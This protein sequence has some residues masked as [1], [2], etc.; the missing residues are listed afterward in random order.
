MHDGRFSYPSYTIRRKFFQIFGGTFY[1]YGPSGEMV[2]FSRQ[3]R[4]RLREDI[5]LYTGEDMAQEVL[6][7]QARQIMDFSAAYDIIDPVRRAKVGAM[8]RR[9][10]KS[11][12][13]DEWIMMDAADREIGAVR[14]DSATRAVIRRVLDQ[15]IP[16]SL[17]L[18]QAYHC[19]IGGAV[20]AVFKQNF[21]PFIMT[22][23]LDFSP[24]TAGL[25]DRRMGMAAGVLLC[26]IEGKE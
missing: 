19:E 1:V 26:A 15:F 14:E 22:L 21:N 7:I 25:L 6:T 8:K 5:R 9:G 10:L 17:I 13:K 18:P 4:F 11:L 20:V 12:V 24:D 16:S 3:A 23:T 2:L